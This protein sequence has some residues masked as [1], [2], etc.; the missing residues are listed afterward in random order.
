MIEWFMAETG[1][2]SRHRILKPSAF[3]VPRTV[4]FALHVLVAPEA[5]KSTGGHIT[6]S[7]GC[8]FIL[9]TSD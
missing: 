1:Q 5:V 6:R 9:A 4:A 8:P 3:A 7:T 2:L